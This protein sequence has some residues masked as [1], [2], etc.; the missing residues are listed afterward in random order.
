[1]RAT[2]VIRLKR[3][4]RVRA[5][6]ERGRPLK[7]EFAYLKELPREYSGPC[8]IVS[9]GKRPDARCDYEERPGPPP[10]NQPNQNEGLNVRRIYLMRAQVSGNENR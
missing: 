7:A 2:L 9:V 8:H 10:P 5:A 3:L 4:E 1:M 6:V